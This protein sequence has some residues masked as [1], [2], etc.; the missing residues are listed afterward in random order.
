MGKI[1]RISPVKLFLGFIYKDE[2][3]YRKSL[4]VIQRRFGS[5]DHESPVFDFSFTDYYEKEMG[6][7]LKKKIVSIE[8]LIQP[9]ELSRIKI[10][11]NSIEEKLSES[12]SRR[13]NI[14]PGYLDNAKLVLASTKDF[15]H[16]IY[17]GKGI[18][19]ELTLYYKDKDY[20]W[21]EW[22]Y[23]DYKSDGY[24]GFFKEARGI[25]ARKV[26]DK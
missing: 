3:V 16:R 19:A 21:L 7:G 14:D 13:I 18:F 24:I 22:T 4:N 8:R 23:P 6:P 11:T 9:C 26:K 1:K 12:G 20:H 5:I 25:Y 10:I 2:A 15:Y 17:I